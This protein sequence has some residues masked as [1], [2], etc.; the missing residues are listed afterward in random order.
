MQAESARDCRWRGVALLTNEA[1][2]IHLVRSQGVKRLK[3]W[4]MPLERWVD[5]LTLVTRRNLEIPSDALILFSTELNPSELVD[6]AFWRHIRY[7]LNVSDPGR[8]L[9]LEILLSRLP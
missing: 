6:D 3:C 2:S 8:D 4:I 1:K 9:F 7:K 5:S